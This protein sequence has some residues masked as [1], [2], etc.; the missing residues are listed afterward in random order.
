MS[1]IIKTAL[2]AFVGAVLTFGT[3]GLYAHF[4][5]KRS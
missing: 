4:K 3:L 1:K 2:L 5:E